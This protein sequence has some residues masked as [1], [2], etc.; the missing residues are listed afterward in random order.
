[1][2]L[3]EPHLSSPSS[4]EMLDSQTRLFSSYSLIDSKLFWGFCFGIILVCFFGTSDCSELVVDNNLPSLAE[5]VPKKVQSLQI[6][7]LKFNFSLI[8][9]QSLN[10]LLTGIVSFEG[11]IVFFLFW[12]YYLWV[13]KNI[14]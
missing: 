3:L 2:S 4:F 6:V 5:A 7:E 12:L 1:L 13:V 8:D 9:F 14:T 11:F 10:S